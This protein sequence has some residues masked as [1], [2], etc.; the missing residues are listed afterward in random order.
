MQMLYTHNSGLRYSSHI[1]LVNQRRHS[2]PLLQALQLAGLGAA[3]CA[4]I[5]QQPYLR[6]QQRQHAAS[7]SQS[8]AWQSE[9]S[10]AGAVFVPAP[11]SCWMASPSSAFTAPACTAHLR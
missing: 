5:V 8:G 9:S 7:E 4:A 6:K 1:V 2:R 3:A 11:A 10:V